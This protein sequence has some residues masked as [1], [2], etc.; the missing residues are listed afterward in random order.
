MCRFSRPYGDEVVTKRVVPKGTAFEEHLYSARMPEGPPNP[1]MEKGFMSRVDSEAADALELLEQRLPESQWRPRLRSAW[2]RFVWGLSIRTPSEITQ[3][4]ST[5][6]EA[7]AEATPG[8]QEA[9]E[10]N[11]PEGAPERVD[12]YLSALDPHEEDKLA[13]GIARRCLDHSG[14]GQIINNMHWNVLDFE[15]SGVPLLTTDRPVWMTT[16]IAD[17]ESFLMIPIG[18][19][20]LFVAT[21]EPKIM[22]RLMAQNRRQQAKDVNRINVQHAVKFVYGIDDKMK[23]FV[24]KHFAT[25]RHSTHMERF[26]AK[27]GH[28]IVAEN[29]P[30]RSSSNTAED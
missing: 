26:A 23:A 3:L 24:Q 1:E 19:T 28:S 27:R 15:G 20:R 9:Y 14:I 6:K 18:P 7:W 17:P 30:L 21:H 25:R 2:S 5:V 10:A 29:S 22:Q 11:R 4:K 8:L 16:T 12:D 13:L